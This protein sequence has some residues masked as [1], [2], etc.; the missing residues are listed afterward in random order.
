MQMTNGLSV[1]HL[2]CNAGRGLQPIEVR[3]AVARA[4]ATDTQV[5]AAELLGHKAEWC[6]MLLGVDQT[7]LFH[8]Q[9]ELRHAGVEIVGSYLSITE[10]SE[11]APSLPPEMLKDRLYPILPPEG[12]PAFCFYPMSKSRVVGANWYLESFDRRRD[13]MYEHGKS[14]RAFAGKVVQLITASTG[15]DTH[16]WGV[17][18]FAQDLKV[19]KDVVYTLRFDE[20]SAKFGEFGD[21]WV[22]EVVD[23][24]DLLL[25]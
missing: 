10:V 5:V 1:L 12:K 19:V 21:F 20:A 3:A 7:P 14:G 6:F 13:M 22:G 17:T 8:F 16:E 4:R 11:Y 25:G 15:L 18:L 24:D 2:F 23:P 9:R